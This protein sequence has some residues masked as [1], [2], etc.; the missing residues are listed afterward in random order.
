MKRNC[1]RTLLSRFLKG[2]VCLSLPSLL[3]VG[4]AC[5]PLGPPNPVNVTLKVENLDLTGKSI[6]VP[7]FYVPEHAA[8][9]GA[10][11]ADTLQILL[12]EKPLFKAV[13]RDLPVVWTHPGETRESLYK[14]LAASAWKQENDLVVVG[15]VEQ[16]FYGG[17]EETVLAVQIRLIDAQSGATVFLASH[18]MISKPKDPSYPLET[19]LTNP[20][21]SPR[22]LAEKVLRQIVSRMR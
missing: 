8:G 11:F 14:A 5:L 22:L 13:R 2:V 9:L 10:M 16:L 1:A 6:A 21:E 12:L 19:K 20:A 4:W 18:R 3:I 7:D 17:L 15:L